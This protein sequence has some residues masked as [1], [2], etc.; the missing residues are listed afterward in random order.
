MKLTTRLIFL[1]II[2]PLS[3]LSQDSDKNLRFVYSQAPD[4]TWPGVKIT[5]LKDDRPIGFVCT[6][7]ISKLLG[8]FVLYD[9]YIK[10][11]FRGNHYA[12]MLAMHALHMVTAQHAHKVYIQAGP[13]ERDGTQLSQEDHIKRLEELKTGY[14][15]KG[16]T[17]AHV[18][19]RL[20]AQGIY[21]IIGIPEDSNYLLV[22]T[23][24]M[25][26]SNE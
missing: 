2:F 15:N 6:A 19:L 18:I 24:Q 16:F 20:L 4:L 3:A 22:Y 23:P 1:L 12:T 10:K 13:F 26:H 21:R 11:E 8:W 25:E 5:L 14:A 17:Q 7:H 9:L